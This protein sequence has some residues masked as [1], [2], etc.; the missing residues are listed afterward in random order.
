MTMG[1]VGTAPRRASVGRLVVGLVVPLIALVA[2]P[3]ACGGLGNERPTSP[4]D[5]SGE[6]EAPARTARIVCDGSTTRV[7][8]SLVRPQP[9]GVHVLVANTSG[10]D[11]AF[12]WDLGRDNAPIGEHELVLQ[13]APGTVR[14]RCQDPGEDAGAPG[15]SVELEIVDPGGLYVPYTLS[16]DE[17]SAWFADFGPDAT[18]DPDPVRS[19]LDSLGW[20]APDDVVE[21][22]GYPE[23]APIVRVV[24]EGEVV[25]YVSFVA[26]GK[27]GWLR[28]HG[29]TCQGV[30]TR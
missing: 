24:R 17:V 11:L 28:E 5:V 18:G 9:D 14:V 15:G 7:E 29:E 1:R 6:A 22:A 21:R 19:V 13:V 10:M 20:L 16:C 8:A 2:S 25:A 30:E 27:G 4:D 3:G 26:D 23:A 12:Q